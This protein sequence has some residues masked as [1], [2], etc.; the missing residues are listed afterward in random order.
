MPELPEDLKGQGDIFFRQ[1]NTS[2]K[3]VLD[4]ESGRKY[5][6]SDKWEDTSWQLSPDGKMLVHDEWKKDA[7]GKEFLLY[8]LLTAEGQVLINQLSLKKDEY[9][10]GWW[11]NRHLKVSRWINREIIGL[12]SLA[13]MDIFTGQRREIPANF[14]GFYRFYPFLLFNPIIYDPTLT[15][16]VY[17]RETAAGPVFVL[18]DIFRKKDLT[19]ISSFPID[20][21]KWSPEGKQFVVVG[22]VDIPKDA[23]EF[24]RVTRTGSVT[25]LTHLGTYYNINRYSWSPDGRYIALWLGDPQDEQLAIMDMQTLE[26]TSYCIHSQD[27]DN[28]PEPIWSPD[29][30]QLVVQSR[31]NKNEEHAILVDIEEEIA[32]EIGKGLGPIFWLRA[33]PPVWLTE[34]P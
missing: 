9:I 11:D 33:V 22:Y 24:F 13:V 20:A 31:D 5:S 23:G 1:W 21:P 32:A 34:T 10:A 12:T 7:A 25:Q 14:P 19:Q 6:L 17:P 30:R 16:V 29:S 26:I 27:P 8:Q 4:M 15:L 3:F 18:R 2:H 28:A